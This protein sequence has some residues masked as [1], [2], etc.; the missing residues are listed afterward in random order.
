MRTPLALLA[1]FAFALSL[2][3]APQTIKVVPSSLTGWI[4]TGTARTVLAAQPK[5]E[6]PAGAQLSRQ[7]NS[8]DLLLRAT[9]QPLV[10][11]ESADWPVME[12]GSAA[13]LIARD[14][15]Y[16]KLWL[17]VADDAPVELPVT[18]ALDA[19]GRAV[20]PLTV[21]FASRNSVLT[22]EAAGKTLNYPMTVA[23][24]ADPEL[25]ISAGT[26]EPWLFDDLEVTFD[27]KIV[28]AVPS[29]IDVSDKTSRD[30]DLSSAHPFT[31]ATEAGA[32]VVVSDSMVTAIVPVKPTP[33]IANDVSGVL[34]IYSQ[35]AIRFGRVDTV[36]SAALRSQKK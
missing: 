16:G 24:S 10:G 27:S 31:T 4:V 22:V 1:A 32:A 35:P 36:R 6:L 5:L 2:R 29:P 21:I 14:G 18:F 12:I 20:A 23:Q 28:S 17:V 7:F 25:V 11:A 9:I 26:T 8:P 33:D 13:L 3:S 34:E 15:S 19:E 30:S